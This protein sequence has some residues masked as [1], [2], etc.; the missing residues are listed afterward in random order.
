MSENEPL[1]IYIHFL[2]CKSRC[3]YCDFFKKLLPKDFDEKAIVERYLEDI[4]YFEHLLGERLVK[5]V[6][7]GGGT[8][9]LLSPDGVCRV[10]DE[11]S[12]NFMVTA[13]AEITLEANPNTF[14]YEKFK[15]FREAG[16]NRLSLGVQSLNEADLK[17][18]GRTH[19][20]SDAKKAME[21]GVKT[22]PKFS[23]DMIY[24]RPHQQ[25]EDWQKEIDEALGF[26][27]KH[28]SLYQ[29]SVEEG[30]V[31]YKKGV[32]ELDEDSSASLYNNT[33]NYLK[34]RGLERYEVSNFAASK[35]AQSSHNMVYWQGGDYIGIGE[36]A[37]GRVRHKGE[38][39]ATLDGQ[40]AEN[41]SA[42]ERATEL[43]FMGL[44]I[45]EGINFERFYKYSGIKF[46]DFV[47][48]LAIKKLAELKMI[49]Y[50]DANI[51]LTDKGFLFL[52]KIISEL[53]G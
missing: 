13:D 53:L 20:V 32:K 46:F 19:S 17:F 6:F 50:D 42:Q 26:G 25:W 7:F 5:S 51:W 10:L 2:Y 47:D 16:I 41:I 39:R 45:K 18:L 8:P 40:M 4:R 36:G 3:P 12:R 38:I 52:D 37:H 9:S 48:N 28:I 43:L 22:F 44:R 21:I 11:I 27:L 35:E 34:E 15:G 24:A 14:D 30:T 29:L 49:C 23:V 1:A 33:V 31:F